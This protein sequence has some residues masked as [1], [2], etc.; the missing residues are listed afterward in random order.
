MDEES[1]CKSE[2]EQQKSQLGLERGDDFSGV[3]SSGKTY[4]R[5]YNRDCLQYFFKIVPSPG[6]K[7]CVT[8]PLGRKFRYGPV[9][10]EKSRYGQPLG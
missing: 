4:F 1:I 10:T 7:T 3:T 5:R 9:V 6:K 2:Q 8:L